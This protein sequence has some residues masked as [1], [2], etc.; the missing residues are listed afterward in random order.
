MRPG[1]GPTRSLSSCTQ[2]SVQKGAHNHISGK[3]KPKEKEKRQTEVSGC[4]L[5]GTRWSLNKKQMSVSVTTLMEEVSLSGTAKRVPVPDLCHA[6]QNKSQLFAVRT[7]KQYVFSHKCSQ[8]TVIAVCGLAGLQVNTHLT[9]K[10]RHHH[11]SAS[12]CNTYSMCLC[13]WLFLRTVCFHSHSKRCG[14]I[15]VKLRLFSCGYPGLKVFVQLTHNLPRGCASLF[16]W[17]LQTRNARMCIKKMY[18]K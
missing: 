7:E 1:D 14:V 6:V 4:G 13:L 5:G 16:T 18:K 9:Y 17:L 2:I 15:D 3:H 12:F 11:V 10:L 8:N